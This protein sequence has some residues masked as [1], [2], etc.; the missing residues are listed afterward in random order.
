MNLFI[1]LIPMLL[2]SAVFIQV[3][4][5]E[6]S[7]PIASD[8]GAAAPEAVPLGLAVRITEDTYVVEG[9][10]IETVTI[11]RRA[12]PDGPAVA[13]RSR[14]SEVL[15]EAVATHP[16]EQDVRIITESTTHYEDIVVV[17]DLARAAGLP[18]AALVGTASEAP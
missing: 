2:L 14:L 15:A 4:I 12:A 3:R 10:G 7:T 9:N 1:I 11:S 13:G 8:A 18:Q 6:I 16:G 5:I 17:M